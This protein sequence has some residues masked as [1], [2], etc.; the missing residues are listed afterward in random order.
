MSCCDP[1]DSIISSLMGG[2][3]IGMYA[4]VRRD[5]SANMGAASAY[6][7]QWFLEDRSGSSLGDVLYISAYDGAAWQWVIVI[8]TPPSGGGSPW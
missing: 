8:T 3:S 4:E 5:V 7:R 6:P 1:A 2:P